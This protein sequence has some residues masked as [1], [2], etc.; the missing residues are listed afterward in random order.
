LE[1]NVTDKPAKASKIEKPDDTLSKLVQW[2]EDSEETSLDARQLM[3]RDVDYKD[4]KQWTD[5]ER[6]ELERRGQPPLTFNKIKRKVNFLTGY[7]SQTKT[8]PKAFPRNYPADEE[9]ADAATDALRY[10]QH[11]SM[12][13]D[14]FSEA[15]EDLIAPGITGL[16]VLYDMNTGKC[17]IVQW[18][19]DRLFFDPFSSKPDFSDARYRGGVVWMDEEAALELYPKKKDIIE[20]TVASEQDRS[21]S[22]TYDDKPRL[23][24]ALI[25]KRKRLRVVQIYWQQG[26][27]WWW[28][29]YT[30]GGILDG[31][32][33]VAFKDEDGNTE[34][35]LIMQSAYVDRDNNRYGEIRELID[36]QDEHNKRRSKALYQMSVRQV[37]ADK[38]AVDN[39][40]HARAQLARPDGYIETNPGKSFEILDT[41]DQLAGQMQL[42]QLNAQ[43]LEYA[44]PNATLMGDAKS[45]ASGKAIIASQQG[46]LAELGRLM[47]RYKFF[48]LAVYRQIWNRVR[49]FWNEEKWVRVT[50]DEN[51]IK[52][53]G[54]NKP[55]TLF[56]LAMDKF[57][58]DG[59]A[60][61]EL[62]QAEEWAKQQ[63]DADVP[64]G[65]VRNNVA[66][67]DMDIILDEAPDT[68]TIQQEQFE[69]IV[70]LAQ[71]GIPF[72]P[73]DLIELSQLRNK[74]KVVA[75]M[76]ERTSP[77][78]SPEQQELMM[79]KENAAIAKDEASAAKSVADAGKT[80]AETDKIAFDAGMSM[81]GSVQPDGFQFQ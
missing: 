6:A 63:P 2:F 58:A 59:L 34:C 46:G 41:N 47:A 42:L 7:E 70:Q 8:D 17:N 32:M 36:D 43:E 75:R 74:D 64:T 71:S 10:I 54:L 37:R 56:D 39:V 35:P 3:E 22:E 49:Q 79:R 12:L 13:E 55:E 81:A 72:A 44:G 40:Q 23:K 67:M 29:H 68:V 28:A 60:G 80:M 76:K 78:A 21:L 45:N 52:F 62:K 15:F 4:G 11:V 9:G 31:N 30:R 18:D 48:K 69:Q 50:D 5:A 77:Q 65:N 33:P 24:W 14:K 19:W 25:G 51:N 1:S 20:Q 73:E 66:K 53:V 57:K 16:E 27:D 38:G 61:D 26:G